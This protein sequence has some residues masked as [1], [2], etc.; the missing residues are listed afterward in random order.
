MSEKPLDS[1]DDRPRRRRRSGARVAEI[2]D[3]LEFLAP[4]SLAMPVDPYGL[5]VGAPTADVRTV[6]V[7]PMASFN[8][9]STAAAHRETLLITAA[10]LVTRPMM[11]IR[12]DDP[13]GAKLAYLLQYRMSL[14]ALPNTFEAAP[15]GFDESL[16][17]AL[18]LA[19]PTVLRPTVHEPQFKIAVFTPPEAVEGVLAAAAEAGAGTIGNYTHCSFRSPGVGTFMPGRGANPAVGLVGRLERVAEEKLEVLVAQRELQ[20]VIAAILEAHPYDEVAYD[21][22]AVS[23]PGVR[24][25]R[26]RIGELPLQ[27]SIETVL[28]QVQDALGVGSVRRSHDSGMQISMLAVASGVTDG[29]F[30]LAHRAGAGALV[31]GGVSQQDLMLA[32]AS[33][34]VVID[35][36]YSSSVSPGLQRLCDQIRE[37]FSADGIE[38][39]YCA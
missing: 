15:G 20:G 7:S 16:A 22:L 30:W 36:G 13:I 38:I 28:A 8:A 1:P 19:A 23:N 3:F 2:V 9:L 25:G 21:V 5:Q 17:E 10:P 31:V 32:D 14:Y 33:T 29:L 34:T 4:P 26:G 27:V 35:I 37:T 24:Y 11:A 18:G 12:S 39:I 6:V